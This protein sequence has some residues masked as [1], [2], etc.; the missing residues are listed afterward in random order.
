[1]YAQ[2][3]NIQVEPEFS[4]IQMGERKGTLPF[5]I[6]ERSWDK[7]AKVWN[8]VY[9]LDFRSMPKGS[10]ILEIFWLDQKKE[11]ESNNKIPLKII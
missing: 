6:V 11:Q 4:L 1:V 8:C 9:T 10:Y 2:N 5:Q 7:K 3:K